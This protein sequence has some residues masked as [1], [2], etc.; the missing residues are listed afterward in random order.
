VRHSGEVREIIT[1]ADP[2]V[3][4]KWKWAKPTNPGTPVWSHSGGIGTGETYKDTVELTFF[5]GG[6]V[7]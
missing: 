1:E 3:I 2:D 4:E 5:K 6:G 7:P